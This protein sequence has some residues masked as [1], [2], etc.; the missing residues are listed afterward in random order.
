MSAPP[1]GTSV[2]PASGPVRAPAPART[3]PEPA[4]KTTAAAA[5]ELEAPPERAR[6][7]LVATLVGTLAGG[8]FGRAVAVLFSRDVVRRAGGSAA[9]GA[10]EVGE[11]SR[12]ALGLL[13]TWVGVSIGVYV[14]L[15]FLQHRAA[16]RTAVTSAVLYPVAAGALAYVGFN[17]GQGTRLLPWAL[18]ATL[19]ARGLALLLPG[20]APRRGR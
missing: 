5:D 8:T 10:R 14:V 9:L 1:P 2:R 4:R 17:S 18:A 11:I 16:G 3:S 15:R 19:V 20:P 12:Q 6:F 13:G 7:G